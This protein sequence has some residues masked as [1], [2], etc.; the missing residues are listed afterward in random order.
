MSKDNAKYINVN[1]IET[2]P[3]LFI[4][5]YIAWCEH[6]SYQV[7]ELY[8]VQDLA[9]LVLEDAKRGEQYA[10]FLRLPENEIITVCKRE[11]LKRTELAEKLGI[12]VTRLE[13]CIS[14]GKCSK[15][16]KKLLCERFNYIR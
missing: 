16:I 7:R 5:I 6:Y 11:N 2:K 14:R 13:N 15:P 10:Q 1:N 3:K 12:R 8:P 4:Q 9:N